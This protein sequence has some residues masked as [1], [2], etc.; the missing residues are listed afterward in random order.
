MQETNGKRVKASH[1]KVSFIVLTLLFFLT[2]GGFAWVITDIRDL[3]NDTATLSKKTAALSKATA[4]L[5]LENSRRISEIQASRVESCKKTYGRVG[6]IF[7][8]FFPPKPRTKEQ[9]A[10]IDKFQNTINSL[11]RHCSEQTKPEESG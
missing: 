10:Q 11:Q 8:P 9:Q 6:E 7:K 1:I 5:A 4:H 3:S 2:L